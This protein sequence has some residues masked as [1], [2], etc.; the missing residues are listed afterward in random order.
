MR[1]MM[2]EARDLTLAYGP[3]RAIQ[4]LSIEVRR[5]EVVAIV[6]ANGAGKTTLIKALSGLMAPQSGDIRLD[7]KSILGLRAHELA[8]RGMLHIPEGRGTLGTL[9]VTE[10]LHVAYDVRPS[11]QSFEEALSQA[12]ARFP[13]LGERRGQMANKMSGGEQQMLALARAIVNP[14]QVLLVDEPSMGLSPLFVTEAF[15]VLREFRNLGMTI[16]IVEQNVRR[17]LRLADRGYVLR[18][19]QVVMSGA[20][21]DLL[22]DVALVSSYLGTHTR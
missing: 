1:E 20:A 11:Q 13:Q 9:T 14:P 10:N 5:G 22:N 16:L 12:F 21:S 19:G 17:A 18:Q 3:I 15:R 4:G 6:G 2:I 7:G 8:M